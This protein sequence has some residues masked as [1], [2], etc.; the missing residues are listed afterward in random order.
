[1]TTYIKVGIPDDAAE[2]LRAD[3]SRAH[4]SMANWAG[5]ILLDHLTA[6][7]EPQPTVLDACGAPA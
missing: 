5:A 4:R 6:E 3:A 2:R 1:M 7:G